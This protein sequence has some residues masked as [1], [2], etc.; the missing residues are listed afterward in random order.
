MK[1]RLAGQSLAKSVINERKLDMNTVM[2]KYGVGVA[3]FLVSILTA[4]QVMTS[5]GLADILQ[6]AVLV[7]TSFTAF[8]LP[9]LG[10]HWRGVLK[11]GADIIG[12]AVMLVIPF[13]VVGHIT[14]PQIVLVVI[15]II[16]A[17][18]TEFGIHIRLD[19]SL[20]TPVEAPGRPP[21]VEEGRHTA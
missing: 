17:A 4:V 1:T 13:A 6:L 19:P 3:S 20:S 9:L 7:L 10:G 5:Y 16:K 18:A 12:A 14:G 15:G 21:I 11:T 8:L 2:Q